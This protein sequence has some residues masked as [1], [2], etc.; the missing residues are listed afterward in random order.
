MGIYTDKRKTTHTPDGYEL[1]THES[2]H[3]EYDFGWHLGPYWSK[4]LAEMRDNKRVMG[5][6]CPKCGTVYVP[7]RKVCGRCFAE[8]NEW[9]ECGPNG[10]LKGFTVVRFPFID[11]NNGHLKKVP[12]TSIWVTLDGSN[13]RM[14]HFCDEI[15]EMKLEVGMRMKPVWARKPRPTSIHAID[16]FEVIREEPVVREAPPERMESSLKMTLPTKKTAKRKVAGKKKTTAKP[17]KK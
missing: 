8:M 10:I 4:Y 5:V 7:P 3:V 13:T 17:K 6:K 9:V 15:D 16:H 12:F 2:G 14:M 11:A 1:L